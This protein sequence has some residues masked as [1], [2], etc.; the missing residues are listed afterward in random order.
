MAKK[1]AASLCVFSAYLALCHI[2][3]TTTL[4][5]TFADV[6][7]A[8]VRQFHNFA[9]KK[10]QDLSGIKEQEQQDFRTATGATKQMGPE[11]R[12]RSIGKIRIFV[13]A[14]ASN[15]RMVDS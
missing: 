2:A 4:N 14:N 5:W 15:H 13:K 3:C 11:H 1:S 9:T 7:S 10:F 12:P 6:Y 8:H